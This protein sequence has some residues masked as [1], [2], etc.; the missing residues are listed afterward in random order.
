MYETYKNK[1]L[2]EI[3]PKANK[4]I[5]LLSMFTETVQTC[6]TLTVLIFPLQHTTNISIFIPFSEASNNTDMWKHIQPKGTCKMNDAKEYGV[7]DV[8]VNY[9]SGILCCIMKSCHKSE[10]S[11]ENQTCEFLAI[12]H[13]T[14]L[15]S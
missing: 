9:L 10:Y 12:L 2:F 13:Y 5:M 15:N 4:I 3:L 8:A 11:Q 14:P 1:K 6:H 7:S